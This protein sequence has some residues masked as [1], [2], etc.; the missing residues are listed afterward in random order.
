[1]LVSKTSE[2]QNQQQQQEPFLLAD[3]LYLWGYRSTVNL[4]DYISLGRNPS[5][6]YTFS[7][8]IFS[9]IVLVISSALNH[10]TASY[11]LLLAIIN[12]RVSRVGSKAE[13]CSRTC[14]ASLRVYF[15]GCLK[16][17][18][19]FIH[20]LQEDCPVVFTYF[21]HQEVWL[22]MGSRTGSVRSGKDS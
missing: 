22:L 13:S 6:V 9:W 4:I 16:G 21:D 1:M 20:S 19:C 11:S 18:Y 10:P 12:N 8:I 3:S 14:N 5:L 2:H 15:P 7:N 17:C